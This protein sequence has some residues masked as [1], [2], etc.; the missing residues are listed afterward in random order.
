MANLDA[1][2]LEIHDSLQDY[3]PKSIANMR[4][5]FAQTLLKGYQFLFGPDVEFE[6]GLVCPSHF[7]ILHHVCYSYHHHRQ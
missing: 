3:T 5:K 2:F 1:S 4:I 6:D 7:F